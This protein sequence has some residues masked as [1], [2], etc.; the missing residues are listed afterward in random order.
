MA[1]LACRRHDDR[2]SAPL[3]ACRYNNLIKVLF[4]VYYV[5]IGECVDAEPLE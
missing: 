1:R 3:L 4:S 2:A 5:S